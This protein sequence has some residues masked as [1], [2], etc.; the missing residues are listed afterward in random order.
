MQRVGNEREAAH[1]GA[2]RQRLVER[3][4]CASPEIDVER[5]RREPDRAPR[6]LVVDVAHQHEEPSR[7]ESARAQPAAK[8][9]GERAQQRVQHGAIVGVGGEQMRHAARG[10]HVGREHG[11][12]VDAVR[13]DVQR[14]ARCAERRAQRLLADRRDLADPF[15]V[16][17]V[18]SLADLR[19]HVREHR[20]RLGG[21]EVRLVARVHRP[22]LGA[23]IALRD[24][25]RRFA[26]ELVDRDAH[27]EPE[28]EP[29][30]GLALEPARDVH[31]G[32]EEPLGAGDVEIRMS[33]VAR[34]DDRCHAGED[35]VQRAMRLG[36]AP[37]IGR[38]HH[39]IGAETSREGH[40]HAALQSFV[41]RFGAHRE[42][43]GTVGGKRRDGH[44]TA[45]QRRVVEHLD[46]GAE[47]GG[48]DEENRLHA[49]PGQDRRVSLGCARPGRPPPH[50]SSSPECPCP[51]SPRPRVSARCSR[52]SPWRPPRRRGRASIS[53]A[54][55]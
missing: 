49:N 46:R 43:D 45:P 15:E 13:V 21:E 29:L 22:H 37:R 48:I 38:A 53:T 40:R 5:V 19:R 2:A 31:R 33:P 54:T 8:A 16:I 7:R 24:G 50:L 41:P 9:L 18:E 34:L 17:I 10:L 23:R 20:D 14:A 51:A 27:D 26:D 35:P 3:A 25:G 4:A 52:S 30:A 1:R 39:E 42:E 47:G 32:T 44:G 55:R 28:R 12:Q 6:G 11:T 36:V